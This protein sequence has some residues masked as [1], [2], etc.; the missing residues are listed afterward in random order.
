MKTFRKHQAF[1]CGV[2]ILFGAVPALAGKADSKAQQREHDKF[3]EKY[4]H[5]VRMTRPPA[6]LTTPHA[7][8]PAELPAASETT[9]AGATVD[10]SSPAPLAA[11]MTAAVATDQTAA[12]AFAGGTTAVYF[13][14]HPDDFLLF[15]LPYRD[16]AADARAVFIFV[17]AGDAGLGVGPTGS[18]YYRAREN[19]AIK[20]IR[21][22]ADA[23][24]PWAENASAGSVTVNGHS[25]YKYSYRSTVAYF[26]RLPDGNG[27][28]GG[29][30]GT[31]STSIVKLYNG[32]VSALKAINGST[33]Y[34]GWSDLAA[35]VTAIVKAEAAGNPNLWL[36]ANDYDTS[37][38]PSDHFDHYATGA[39][40]MGVQKALPCASAAYYLGYSLAGVSNLSKEDALNKTG[41]FASYTTGLN[42]KNYFGAWDETHKAWLNGLAVRMAPGNGAAC[43]Y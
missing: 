39:L 25:I 40:A 27:D 19:A 17:T 23:M 34:K 38:N 3:L 15:S 1:A 37:A 42:E 24:R 26:L 41:S 6:S 36:N 12:A 5:P 30:P 43:A 4:S 32:S 11:P 22:M 8:A 20:S 16:V 7:N 33:T 31:G 29:F 13:S 9:S 35:T 21:F 18:P 2:A 28:G 14:A 10:A